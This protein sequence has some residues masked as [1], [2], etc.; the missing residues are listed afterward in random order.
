MKYRIPPGTGL[1]RSGRS[2]YGERGLKLDNNSGSIPLIRR[3]LPIR[4]AWIEICYKHHPADP[5][6]SLPIR[7]AWIEIFI[8][9]H[10]GHNITGRSPYGERGLKSKTKPG[11]A[12]ERLS[13]PIRGAWIEINIWILSIFLMVSSLPIRGA[14]I[15]ITYSCGACDKNPV[16]PHT[17]SVD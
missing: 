11:S 1:F 6:W 10:D 4:G 9:A 15:E 12:A 13:L 17:G 7:G 14:W 8:F 2:P 16:A 3:S 5:Y